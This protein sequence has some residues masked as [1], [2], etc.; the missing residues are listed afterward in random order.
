MKVA[1]PIWENRISPV[2]DTA[3][4]LL[5]A[6]IAKDGIKKRSETE[7]GASELAGRCCRI[8]AM[9]VD[10]L[11]CGAITRQFAQM[12]TAAGIEVIPGISGH[13]DEVLDAFVHGSLTDPRFLMP[14]CRGVRFG[15]RNANQTRG[16]CRRLKKRYKKG[17]SN[18]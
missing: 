2:F 14:G 4:R 15:R 18:G 11:I 10:F 17:G 7:L 8:Q 1:I 9:E 6:E 13:P 16:I 12:L 3:S 5:I